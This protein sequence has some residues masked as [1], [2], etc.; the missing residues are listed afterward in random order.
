MRRRPAPRGARS[1]LRPQ[2][3]RFALT[4]GWGPPE[5]GL[6]RRPGGFSAI[7]VIV[8]TLIVAVS[9][10]PII[11]L[12]SSGAREVAFDEH[13]VAAQAVATS[14]VE[15]TIEELTAGG[16]RVI[17]R[18][19]DAGSRHGFATKDFSYRAA[20]RPV[21]GEAWL[22]LVSVAVQWQLPTDPAGAVHSFRLDRL[23]SRPDAAFTGRYPYRRIME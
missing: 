19:Q 9:M 2:T 16:F 4:G 23:V 12:F 20:A 1:G 7:E 5:A 17:E 18:D 8:V 11:D 22:W 15:Q 13:M 21:D 6:P 3:S 10:I 14:L